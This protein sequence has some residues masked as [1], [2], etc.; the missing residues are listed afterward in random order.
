MD[1]QLINGAGTGSNAQRG[2]RLGA[3]KVPKNY[4]AKRK[5]N[6]NALKSANQRILDGKA[7]KN[8]RKLLTANGLKSN[9]RNSFNAILNASKVKTYRTAK[10][11][12]V[13]RRRT[14]QS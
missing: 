7:R 8:D 11:G 10:E 9:G 1:I 13:R 4:G 2:A 5:R 6:A 12:P 14:G 3:K